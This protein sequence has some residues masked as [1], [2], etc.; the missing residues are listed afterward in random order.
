MK[1]IIKTALAAYGMSGQVFHGPL[2][3]VNDG[4]EVAAVLERSKDNSRKLFPGAVIVRTYEDLL[5]VP[6]IELVIVNAPDEFHYEMTRQA[7]LAGKHVVVEKPATPFKAMAREL[8]DLAE[9]KKL[10]LTVFQNRR[11]DGDFL[12][13]RKIL[14]QKLL[15]ELAE[16]EAH[17]DRYRN[18]IDSSS[19]KEKEG[20]HSGVLYNL[21]SHMADQVYCLF[22]KPLAVTAHLKILREGGKAV[23]YYDIRLDYP[24][25][26]AILKSSYLV[27]SPGP[28][29]I[30][31]GTNGSFYK[32]GIDPQEELLKTGLLPAG[33]TWGADTAENY[34]RL[35]YERDGLNFD[36]VVET[37]RGKYNLFYDNIYDVLRNGAEPMVKPDEVL[38]VL[39][40]LEACLQSNR[41]R[42]T[43][44]LEQEHQG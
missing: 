17:Y 4:F 2:L 5:A 31:H 14:Q 19:W 44:Y 11:L 8:F 13:V 37:E 36:S 29:Y 10:L 38:N 3:K 30:I 28:R 18:W 15:G 42:R 21:G 33:E 40:I 34:G 43:I 12:T 9:E 16:Y 27:K 1:Q 25:F 6:G 23:D 41:E 7:L 22:G 35:C 26:S 24:H 20:E 32:Q 39:H